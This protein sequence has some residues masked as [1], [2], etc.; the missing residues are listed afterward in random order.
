MTD[1]IFA[2]LATIVDASEDQERALLLRQAAKTL[3][4]MPTAIG[5]I[6]TAAL[7]PEDSAAAQ[8]A[9]ALLSCVLDEARMAVE[10]DTP[11]GEA[12]ISVVAATLMA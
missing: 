7:D 11:E 12:L 8:A 2:L 4:F 9:V 6:A 10:N 5:E 1:R 3:L